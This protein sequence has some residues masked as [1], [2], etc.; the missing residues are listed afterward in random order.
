MEDFLPAA[1]QTSHDYKLVVIHHEEFSS[2]ALCPRC[3]DSC[4]HATWQTNISG[5]L[6]TVNRLRFALA[7]LFLLDT[8]E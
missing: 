3:G 2:F 1:E 7:Y 8:E 5:M 6:D 4:K